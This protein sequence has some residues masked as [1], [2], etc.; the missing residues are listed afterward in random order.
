VTETEVEKSKSVLKEQLSRIARTEIQTWLDSENKNN[1]EDYSL[2]M[3]EAITLT[4]ETLAIS[5]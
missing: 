3:G 4:G 1:A 5:S 2:L